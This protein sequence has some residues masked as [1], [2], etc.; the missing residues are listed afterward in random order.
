MYGSHI[1]SGTLLLPGNGISGA[2]LEV[3][4]REREL[5]L[6]IETQHFPEIGN[7]REISSESSKKLRA[8][9]ND[10]STKEVLRWFVKSIHSYY[11]SYNH[12]L[13]ESW[14]L[15]CL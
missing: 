5:C 6:P 13:Y 3:P 1:S 14:F 2:F 10:E 9:Y 15:P 4:R 12:Q 7:F 11:F 8:K